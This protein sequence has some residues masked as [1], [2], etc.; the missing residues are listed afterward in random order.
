MPKKTK[1]IK[2]AGLI[3]RIDFEIT[4]ERIACATTQLREVE[5]ELAADIQLA[6]EVHAAAIA[7][8]REEIQAKAALCEKY[9]EDHRDE[10]LPEK[11]VKSAETVFARYGF[12]LGN[13]TVVLLNKRYTW[14]DVI[15][16]LKEYQVLDVIRTSFEV[17][18]EAILAK[19]DS[20][21]VVSLRVEDSEDTLLFEL[22]DFGMKIAQKETFFIEP[23][24]DGAET[25]KTVLQ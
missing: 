14:E 22:A 3:N 8:L 1:R 11:D 9:A 5:A 6:Q 17:N 13:R 10:L 7:E 12:R 2:V 21:G 20:G 24:V 25:I 23:K 4:I 18:K 16:T 19:T 15:E